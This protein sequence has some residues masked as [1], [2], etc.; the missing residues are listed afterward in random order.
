MLSAPALI[1]LTGCGGIV[2]AHPSND[3]F[4]ITPG[5]AAVD[6]NCTGCNAV[7][8][9]GRAVQQFGATLTGGGAAPVVWSVAGGD[10]VGGAGSI[11]AKGQYTPP[12]YLTA[13]RVQVLVTAALASDPTLT[14]TSVLNITPGFLQPLTPENAALGANGSVTV[15]GILAE[16][17]G[18]TGIEFALSKTATGVSIPANSSIGAL[19]ATSCQHSGQAFTI[20]SVTYTAPAAVA[21]TGAAYV[22]ATVEAA[23][24]GPAARIA[25]PVLLNTA[26]VSSNPASHQVQFQNTVLLG[27]SGGNN[28]DYD[29]KG[30]HVLDCCGGTLGALIQDSTG[31]NYILGNNHVLARSDHASFGEAIVQPGLIDNNCSP[32][33]VGSG[34]SPVATLTGW[35]PLSAKSTNADAAIALVTSRSIDTSGS[36][37]ELGSRQS[38]GTLAAAPP[39]V[40]STGGRGESASLALRVAKSGRTTGLTCG[41]VTAVDLDV[42]ID[43]FEDCA[44]TKP[45]LTKTFTHQIGLSGNAFSDAGDSGSLLVDAANAEPVGLFFAG[46]LD[47]AGVS[48]GVA[49]P[50]SDVLSELG[51]QAGGLS[52]SFVGAADHPVSCLSY[53][54][55]SV[56]AAQ[57]L[58]L[59][60]AENARAQ[61]A[62]GE[63]RG[64][65]NPSAGILGVAIGKSSDRPG[66]AAILIYVNED[67]NPAIPATISGVRTLTIPSNAFAVAFGLAP[68]APLRNSAATPSLSSAALTQ[69]LAAKQ[70]TA[71]DLMRSNAAFF[72]VG[73]GQSLDNPKEAA[74][75][76]YVDRKRVPTHLPATVQGLRIRYL[77]MDRLHV[78]RSYATPVQSALHC[79]PHPAP[80]RPDR[81]DPLRLLRPLG[82]NY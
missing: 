51:A 15:S 66:E 5:T 25:A 80:S 9:Q 4:S 60:A 70:Q 14:A 31:R 79:M 20:C 8:A 57:E 26:G 63:A 18:N 28:G 22:V 24:S 6:T 13:D 19:S 78:T 10:R 44:E 36:I 11:D 53:G 77:F 16:A 64:L 38:D 2:T 34:V 69:A 42:T 67:L 3:A 62:L 1:L 29:L 52:Y 41:S 40:S 23:G 74:L 21:A 73:V 72:A 58:S 7:N 12:G 48:Q 43:Y 55:S 17:G 35:L 32:L 27:S 39:G 59:S 76:V 81:F 75:I 33:G 50:A 46:G 68:R 56:E 45:Y 82:L 54:D 65:V 47:S 71:H 30:N 61:Q 37:L 49:N